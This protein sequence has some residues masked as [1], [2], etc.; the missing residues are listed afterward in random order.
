MGASSE[1]SPPDDPDGDKDLRPLAPLNRG[2]TNWDEV[3]RTYCK[4]P[5]CERR[6]LDLLV[7]RCRPKQI[8]RKLQVS[9][10]TVRNQIASV[11]QKFYVDS[12]AEL[13]GLFTT[14]LYEEARRT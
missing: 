3:Y 6:V 9:P 10:A 1:S 4:L 13:V 12:L 7:G 11:K 2:E 8:A 14:A 5:A